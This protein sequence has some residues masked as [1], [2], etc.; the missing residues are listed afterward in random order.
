M[1]LDTVQLTNTI[2]LFQLLTVQ[3][4]LKN[5]EAEQALHA[6]ISQLNDLRAGGASSKSPKDG[7][8]GMG[9]GGGGGGGGTGLISTWK[10]LKGKKKK[11]RNLTAPEI[12]SQELKAAMGD[13]T[14][15][16]TAT[17]MP[18]I[19]NEKKDGGKG[20][21]RFGKK[22]SK[23]NMIKQQRCTSSVTEIVFKNDMIEVTAAQSEESNHSQISEPSLSQPSGGSHTTDPAVT[24]V[25]IAPTPTS[26]V[27]VAPPP[28]SEVDIKPPPTSSLKSSDF[29]VL[30]PLD[31]SQGSADN[32]EHFSTQS[33]SEVGISSGLVEAHHD[34]EDLEDVHYEGSYL[35]GSARLYK[36]YGNKQ[37]KLNLERVHA[38]L[39]SSKEM[40]P[41]DLRVLQDW[42]GWMVASR[43]IM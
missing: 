41:V 24:E 23:S 27:D 10:K 16:S 39:E 28:I 1:V 20:K 15:V 22:Q 33:S 5:E 35:L 37:H 2:V 11:Q 4:K 6:R 3:Q 7:G 34:N 13:D 9:S 8:S 40:E 32:D 30:E 21:T 36:D 38:F 14:S 29:I 25:D 43:D 17:L 31:L 26:E 12:T 18:V 19:E 42:D